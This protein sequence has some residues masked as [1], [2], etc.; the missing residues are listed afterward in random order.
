MPSASDASHAFA[1]RCSSAVLG[2]WR[3]VAAAASCC[4]KAIR[5][6]LPC[7]LPSPA[8]PDFTMI[9]ASFTARE[10]PP[11]APRCAGDPGSSA[12]AGDPVPSALMLR[13]ASL[14][15]SRSSGGSSPPTMPRSARRSHAKM[16]PASIQPAGALDAAA[17]ASA[18]TPRCAKRRP[19]PRHARYRR[20]AVRRAR[21]VLIACIA[22]LASAC[23]A[24][25][26][27]PRRPTCWSARSGCTTR[28]RSSS[29]AAVVLPTS[30]SGPGACRRRTC[31][32]K[33]QQGAAGG[34]GRRRRA[35]E[36]PPPV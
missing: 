34:A 6:R 24:T 18:T 31:A 11:R 30:P 1:A 36:G 33:H 26:S 25:V 15:G 13:T 28:R 17:T 12:P 5:L 7:G 8:L 21:A 3:A 20:G 9:T 32:P 22:M 4:A 19:M 35:G 29:A 2:A 23:S 27:W 16:Q 10:V 14:R